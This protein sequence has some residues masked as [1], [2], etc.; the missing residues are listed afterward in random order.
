M[1]TKLTKHSHNDVTI[2]MRTRTSGRGILCVTKDVFDLYLTKTAEVFP[3]KSLQ[4]LFESL[5][6][7]DQPTLCNNCAMYCNY[8]I[9]NDYIQTSHTHIKLDQG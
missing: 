5:K 8:A 4:Q 6:L 2:S 9:E 1:T 7:N 3:R